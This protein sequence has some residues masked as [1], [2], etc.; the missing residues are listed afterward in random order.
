MSVVLD[1]ARK[2]IVVRN[3]IDTGWLRIKKDGGRD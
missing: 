1:M 3:V 2:N